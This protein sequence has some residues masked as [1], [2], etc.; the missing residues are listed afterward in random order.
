MRQVDMRRRVR[1][2]Y[3]AASAEHAEAGEAWYSQA[4]AEA[5]R[6]ASQYGVTVNTAAGVIAALSPRIQW[7]HNVRLADQVLAAGGDP[8]L[9]QGGGFKANLH[10]ACRIAKGERPSAVL[11]GRKVRSFYANIIGWRHSVTVDTWAC[12]V[13]GY[14]PGYAPSKSEYEE[15]S[16]AY[17]AVAREYGVSAHEVQAVTWVHIRGRAQ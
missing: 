12:Q 3:E 2:A 1:K 11:G 6:M 13:V 5:A 14:P 17:K 7:G 4:Q 10:K 8:E 9:V 16:R 15:I